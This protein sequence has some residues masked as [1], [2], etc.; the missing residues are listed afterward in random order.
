[1]GKHKSNWLPK[2]K[3]NSALEKKL[4]D[5][6]AKKVERYT[7]LYFESLLN[8]GHMYSRS[9][10]MKSD[11]IDYYLCLKDTDKNEDSDRPLL[12]SLMFDHNL[13]NT[14][15]CWFYFIPPFE[16][17]VLRLNKMNFVVWDM[18][19]I[20][21][22]EKSYEVDLREYMLDR[23]IWIL[24]HV[25]FLSVK[26]DCIHMGYNGMC[27]PD[28]MQANYDLVKDDLSKQY[29]DIDALQ[30]MVVEYYHHFD[31]PNDTKDFCTHFLHAISNVNYILSQKPAKA[32]RT[33]SGNKVKVKKGE[34]GEI[35]PKITRAL[36][37][38][39]MIT[40]SKAP[41]CPTGEII[42]HYSVAEWKTRGH[43]RH[44]KNG[45]IVYIAPTI[46]HRK[47][48]EGVKTE[49]PQQVIKVL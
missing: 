33:G 13:I 3:Q 18:K 46:H 19:E 34:I 49:T 45:K 30:K 17:G 42:R 40:S 48:L 23:G 27:L 7:K 1:M 28:I 12:P 47:C 24:N 16:H 10:L 26:D 35:K 9:Q 21:L 38:G 2:V 20:N 29:D 36:M 5:V 43:L 39:I 41:K 37:N 14:P 44:Y 31:L 32:V 22:D 11:I 25:A 15:G 4:Q 8:C 6:A